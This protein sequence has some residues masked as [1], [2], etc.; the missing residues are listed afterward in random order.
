MKSETA[1][2]YYD[3]PASH[4]IERKGGRRYVASHEI[5]SEAVLR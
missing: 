5:G 4:E 3:K 1:K 2:Q